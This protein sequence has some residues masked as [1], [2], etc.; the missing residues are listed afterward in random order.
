MTSKHVKQYSLVS[1]GFTVKNKDGKDI[2]KA[3]EKPKMVKKEYTSS[4]IIKSIEERERFATFLFTNN[5]VSD[6]YYTRSNSWERFLVDNNLIGKK[7]FEP[8]YG[9]GTSRKSLDGLVDVVGEDRDFWEQVKDLNSTFNQNEY[10]LILS[11]P[12]FS[13]K[14][15]V[16]QTLLE[17]KKDFALILPWQSFYDKKDDEKKVIKSECPLKKYQAIFGGTYTCFNM[18]GNELRFWSPQSQQYKHIG[19]KIL[20]WKF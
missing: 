20:Y 1:C 3:Y 6:E 13:F 12:P 4:D 17:K 16:I 5:K 18:K 2:S 15:L 9:D 19:C 14:W 11:N 7:V 8:F 10:D